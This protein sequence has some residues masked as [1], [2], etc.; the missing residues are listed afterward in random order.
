MMPPGES[1]KQHPLHFLQTLIVENS[2]RRSLCLFLKLSSEEARCEVPVEK[3]SQ[4]R[5]LVKSSSTG[6]SDDTGVSCCLAQIRRENLLF[7]FC[8]CLPLT[9]AL[10]LN[11]LR[12]RLVPS[13]QNRRPNTGDQ[14]RKP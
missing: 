3:I 7:V 4:F 10:Q 2:S 1:L 12:R 11:S 8:D 14:P 5:D 6:G 13:Y 9:V